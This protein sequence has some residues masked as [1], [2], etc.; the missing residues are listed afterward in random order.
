MIKKLVQAECR[1]YTMN[2]WSY[3]KGKQ[4]DSIG[5]PP[6]VKNG[7]VFSDDTTKAEVLKKHFTSVLRRSI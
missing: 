5:V 1:K 7:I 6:L 4:Q 2:A 3:T